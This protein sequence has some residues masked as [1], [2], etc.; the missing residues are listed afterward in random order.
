[1]ARMAQ[2]ERL[3]NSDR[4]ERADKKDKTDKREHKVQ[5]VRQ[6]HPEKTARM[7]KV[8]KSLEKIQFSINF[9]VSFII[10]KVEIRVSMGFTERMVKLE[11]QELPDFQARVANPEFME[12]SVRKEH[13]E[14]MARRERVEL[15]EAQDRQ[16]HLVLQVIILV[17]FFLFFFN[18]FNCVIPN[19]NLKELPVFLENLE[20]LDKEVFLECLEFQEFLQVD[21]IFL[22]DIISFASQ[23]G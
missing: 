10:Y 4:M 13:L 14:L 23:F 5:L 21:S 17:C 19:Q 15:R 2:T 9:Y 8:N 7:V 18:L 20:N 12:L 11:I 16:D 1:M 22:D 6:G 3:D